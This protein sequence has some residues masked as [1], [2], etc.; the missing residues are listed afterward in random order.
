MSRLTWK[1]LMMK[2][3]GEIEVKGKMMTCFLYGNRDKIIKYEEN[4][5]ISQIIR[6]HTYKCNGEAGENAE[7]LPITSDSRTLT[8]GKH[9]KEIN[10]NTPSNEQTTTVNKSPKNGSTSIKKGKS[11]K[12]N[13]KS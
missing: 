11:T 4:K 2:E 13:T 3:Q 12:K 6:H 1:K 7:E 8:N 5:E 9:S 10:G